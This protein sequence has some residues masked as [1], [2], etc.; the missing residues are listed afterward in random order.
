MVNDEQGDH[1]PEDPDLRYLH[2]YRKRRLPVIANR[3]KVKS[4]NST[5][6]SMP[7]LSSTAPV[8][9]ARRAEYS[10][11]TSPAM[12]RFRSEGRTEAWEEESPF[13]SN[14]FG[15]YTNP[16]S[17]QES[18]AVLSTD[19]GAMTTVMSPAA[20]G[21]QAEGRTPSPCVGGGYSGDFSPEPRHRSRSTSWYESEEFTPPN[22]ARENETYVSS[23]ERSPYN[24]RTSGLTN[25]EVN[26][27]DSGY[28]ELSFHS[29][30]PERQAADE[31]EVLG[32]VSEPHVLQQ[33]AN[34][35]EL[36][37]KFG[38]AGVPTAQR[39]VIRPGEMAQALRNYKG[40]LLSQQGAV[41]E[42]NRF[43]LTSGKDTL[44]S[45]TSAKASDK[46]K[47][48][49]ASRPGSRHGTTTRAQ[50]MAKRGAEEAALRQEKEKEEKQKKEEERK[51]AKA[52]R[53]R[54]NAVY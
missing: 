27:V 50:T 39:H 35:H 25:S 41:K 1:N 33:P 40:I 42:Q 54:R 15:P 51:A 14:D 20:S 47:A 21:F 17:C 53:K 29:D 16:P 46:T 23:P 45:A 52:K 6:L 13:Q 9:E 19:L 8:L 4:L 38:T 32:P 43:Q 49:V 30:A 44:A 22:P 10:P 36:L 31:D 26:T 3:N 5:F 2:V 34:C 12:T 37:D 11:I 7:A 18:P 48:H 28:R 24:P